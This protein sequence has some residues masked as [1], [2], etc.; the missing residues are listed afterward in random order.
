MIKVMEQNKDYKI[1]RENLGTLKDVPL[2]RS[3]KM[4]LEGALFEG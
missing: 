3:W 2:E 1:L 4:M